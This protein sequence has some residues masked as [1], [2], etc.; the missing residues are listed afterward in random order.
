VTNNKLVFGIGKILVLMT[1]VF[2]TVP[3]KVAIAQQQDEEMNKMQMSKEMMQ[4]MIEEEISKKIILK[5]TDEVKKEI[6]MFVDI[7][8]KIPSMSLEEAV[9]NLFAVKDIEKLLTIHAEYLVEG[10]TMGSNQT[11]MMK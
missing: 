2:L 4:N 1:T 7:V 9:K 3:S 8:D 6:P 5:F 10:K 11:T